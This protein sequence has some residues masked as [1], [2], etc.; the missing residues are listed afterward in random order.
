MHHNP[1][2]GIS[3]QYGV[4]VDHDQEEAKR[5]RVCSESS[6]HSNSPRVHTNVQNVVRCVYFQIFQILIVLAKEGPQMPSGVE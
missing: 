1:L 4:P 3:A 5:I 6:P 2:G